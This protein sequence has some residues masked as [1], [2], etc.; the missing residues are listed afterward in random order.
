MNLTFCFVGDFCTNVG[1]DAGLCD[2]AVLDSIDWS[3]NIYACC[4]S[5]H[6]F[7]LQNIVGMALYGYKQASS[8]LECPCK[9]DD[10]VSHYKV[11]LFKM[12]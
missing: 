10:I 2:S 5:H 9:S 8:L 4:Y 7:G 11:V 12:F 3:V 6:G 1:K